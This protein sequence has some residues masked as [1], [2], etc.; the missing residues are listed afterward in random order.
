MVGTQS[1]AVCEC[2]EVGVVRVTAGE[3][4]PVPTAGPT[5]TRGNT[6][7]VGATTTTPAVTTGAS[8]EVDSTGAPSEEPPKRKEPSQIAKS[9]SAFLFYHMYF[10]VIQ[11]PVTRYPHIMKLILL[12]FFNRPKGF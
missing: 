10:R 1:Y 12:F 9:E 5:T 2:T 8:D 7:T 3:L 11:E 6:T 4:R